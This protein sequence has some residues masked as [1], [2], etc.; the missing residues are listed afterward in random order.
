MY[1]N[2]N[3]VSSNKATKQLTSE[4]H[5]SI[6]SSNSL[7]KNKKEKIY[8]DKYSYSTSNIILVIPTKKSQYLNQVHPQT[9]Q[10]NS[11]SP[12]SKQMTY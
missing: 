8:L 7:L 5:S 6:H 9:T 10:E 2:F 1:V 4:I 12:P 3:C 11:T